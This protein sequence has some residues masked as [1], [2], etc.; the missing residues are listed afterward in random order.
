MLYEVITALLEFRGRSF[1]ADFLSGLPRGETVELILRE[2]TPDR[3]AFALTGRH[4]SDD[5]I[6]LLGTLSVVSE[7]GLADTPIVITS[8]S[9]HYTKLYECPPQTAY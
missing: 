2:K 6:K 1:T 9:I 3:I 5:I 7:Q 4:A 8:Y